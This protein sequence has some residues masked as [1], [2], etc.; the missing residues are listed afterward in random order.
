M[1]V[2]AGESIEHSNNVLVHCSSGVSRSATVVLAFLIQQTPLSLSDAW[3]L[4]SSKRRAILPN[5]T[6]YHVSAM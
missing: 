3:A 2:R 5:N 6:F 1:L 4:L